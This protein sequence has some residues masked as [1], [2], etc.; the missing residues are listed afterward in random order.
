VSFG[1]FPKRGTITANDKPLRGR[2]VGIGQ[3]FDRG[4]YTKAQSRKG[5]EKEKK[6]NDNNQEIAKIIVDAD[7]WIHISA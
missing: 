1:G 3:V 6:R 2:V 4:I 7:Y 5:A